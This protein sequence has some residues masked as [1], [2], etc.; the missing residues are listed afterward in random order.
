M[1]VNKQKN[2]KTVA[3]LIHAYANELVI[4]RKIAS[5]T[6]DGGLL[7]YNSTCIAKRMDNLYIL[8]RY[9]GSGSFGSGYTHRN[10]ISALNTTYILCKDGIDNYSITDAIFDKIRGKML[11]CYRA[12]EE[13]KYL[14]NSTTRTLYHCTDRVR[15]LIKDFTD[16]LYEYKLCGYEARYHISEDPRYTSVY[17]FNDYF[18]TYKGWKS[19]TNSFKVESTIDDLINF[20]FDDKTQ[21]LIDYKYWYISKNN[22][23]HL[24]SYSV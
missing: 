1:S 10:I 19:I 20:K 3:E 9:D 5:Y 17:K 16:E 18:N 4:K 11:E 8:R 13:L 7:Y 22:F 24:N 21:D 12:I 2:I 14:A 6:V 15:G 23:F